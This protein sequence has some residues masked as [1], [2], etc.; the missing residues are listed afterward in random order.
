M[1]HRGSRLSPEFS[2]RGV[3]LLWSTLKSKPKITMLTLERV[4]VRVGYAK[5]CTDDINVTP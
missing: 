2:L 3:A 1:G 4:A 5:A